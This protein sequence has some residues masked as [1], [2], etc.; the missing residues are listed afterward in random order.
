MLMNI[1]ANDISRGS[2]G[3]MR[4]RQTL[5]GAYEIM[6]ASAYQRAENLRA[7]RSGR[8]TSLRNDHTTRE[9]WSVLA[10]VMGVTQE[11]INHRRL[12]AE[13]HAQGT[14]HRMLGLT[15][16]PS[17]P[18]QSG[19]AEVW[20]ADESDSV[21][22]AT[23][24]RRKRKPSRQ[25]P[26]KELDEEEEEE[27]RYRISKDGA[28]PPTK[29]R[30]VG[31]PV[32]GHTVFTTDDDEDDPEASDESDDPDGSFEVGEVKERGGG[33]NRRDS[34]ERRSYWLSKGIGPPEDSD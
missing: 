9:E 15:P 6:M 24:P 25:N 12:V 30:R 11:T 14:L 22:S 28:G 19:V 20:R 34:A 31:G 17:H 26:A 18:E 5:A 29:R 13:V 7:R 8:Y 27:S 16:A 33:K 23:P 32:D 3:I 2:Y 4:V 21:H 1:P 10:S